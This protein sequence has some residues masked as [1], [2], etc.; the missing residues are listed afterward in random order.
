MV[1]ILLA[2]GF[3]ANVPQCPAGAHVKV[4]LGF[5]GPLVTIAA[6]PEVALVASAVG[7]GNSVLNVTTIAAGWYLGSPQAVSATIMAAAIKRRVDRP[8]TIGRFDASGNTG[9]YHGEF[10]RN[11]DSYRKAQ[12]PSY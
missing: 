7:G 9:V 4:T 10:A 12:R 8:E 1:G 5:S 2:T 3:G 11:C 6:I